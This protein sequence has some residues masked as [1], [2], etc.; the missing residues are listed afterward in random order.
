MAALEAQSDRRS[1]HIP[2]IF[3]EL[4][5]NEF[6]FVGA[7]RLVQRRIGPRG[8]CW[9]PSKELRREMQRLNFRMRAGDHQPFDQVAQLADVS[10]PI[11]AGE[12]GQ[13]CVA[14]VLRFTAIGGGKFREKIAR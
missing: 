11:I 9:K 14:D 3:A 6:A 10:R 1:R 12:H 2:L 13:R 5:Q 7:A 4:A 8:N